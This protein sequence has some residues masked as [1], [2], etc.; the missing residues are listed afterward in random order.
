MSFLSK[1]VTRRRIVLACVRLVMQGVVTCS[2]P[3][4]GLDDFEVTCVH[5]ADCASIQSVP[6]S[7]PDLI[8]QGRGLKWLQH[9]RSHHRPN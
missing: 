1:V 7:K 5:A 3:Q 8:G 9:E 4:A 2:S 6:R